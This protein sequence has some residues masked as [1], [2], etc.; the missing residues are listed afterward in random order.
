MKKI[1]IYMALLSVFSNAEMVQRGD[2]G[3]FISNDDQKEMESLLNRK[4]SIDEVEDEINEVDQY[5]DKRKI[6]DDTSTKLMTMPKKKEV[7][8]GGFTLPTKE[9]KGHK[10]R[11]SSKNKHKQKLNLK[12]YSNIMYDEQSYYYSL[13]QPTPEKFN[14]YL[15]NHNINKILFK[16]LVGYGTTIK[17]AQASAYYYDYYK[18]EAG[19]AENFYK[20]LYKRKNELDLTGKISL[21]DYLL[22]TGRG[23]KISKVLKKGECLASFG[24]N[25]KICLYYLGLELYFKTG[26]TKTTYFRLTKD[27]FKQAKE[28]YYMKN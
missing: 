6:K 10:K 16:N 21:A 8:K 2:G 5:E 7:K 9:G 13:R 23:D 24:K 3:V 25:N 12:D 19:T 18:E 28:L 15:K 17:E 4:D 1:L 26:K 22:R 11:K 27:K 20:I 14:D